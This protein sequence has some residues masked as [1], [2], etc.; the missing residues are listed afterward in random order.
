M[1][2]IEIIDKIARRLSLSD[3]QNLQ[4]QANARYILYGVRESEAN[5]PRFKPHLTEKAHQLAYLYLE[6]ACGY[7]EAERYQE[8]SAYFERGAELLEYNNVTG[9]NEDD[10]TDFNRMVGSLSYYCASQYSKAFI[11]LKGRT[12][13]TPICR[14]LW[15]FLAKN[16][17][18]LEDDAKTI[19][20]SKEGGDYNQVYDILLARVMELTVNYYYYGE[21]QYLGKA[22]ETITDATELALLGE[23]PA[24][25]WLFRLVR[26]LIEGIQ[27]SS[28]WANVGHND[29][30]KVDDGGWIEAFKNVGI[31]YMPIFD[32]SAKL[33]LRNYINSLTFREHPVTELF[34]S[35]RKALEKVLGIEGAVVSMPTSSGK[36]RIAELVILQTLMFDATSKVLYIAPYRSLSFEMEETFN[37]TFKPMEYYVTHLYGSAQ[38]T[39][40]DRQEMEQARVV[41]A[42]PEKAKAILRANDTMVQDIRLVVMDEGHLLGEGQ[43]EVTNEMFSEEL[44]RIV[45][46]NHGRFLVLSAVLPNAEDMSAWLARGGDHVVKDTWRPSSQRFGKILCYPSRIDI[47]WAGEPRCFNPSFVKTKGAVDKKKLIALAA[48]KLSTLGSI[49][50]YCPTPAQVLSNAR[51]MLALLEDEE[52]VDWGNDPDW[53]RFVLVCKECEEDGIYLELAKKGILCHS[54]ALKSDVRRF[55]EHLLRKGKA[56][57]IYATNTLAQG[58]NLG[59]STVIVVGTYIMPDTYLTNRD[60]WNMA[61]RAGRSFVDTE[62]KILFVCNCK[63]RETE[64]KQIWVADKYLDSDSI[65]KVE[66]GV[67]LWLRKLKEMQEKLDLDFDYLLQLIAENNL[68]DLG[69]A[70]YFFEMID[71]SLLSLDLSYREDDNDDAG[72]VEDHFRKSLAVIQ[73]EQ[74]EERQKNIAILKARVHAV[75]RMTQGN[76]MPQAFASSGIPLSVALYFEEHADRLNSLADE[77]LQSDRGID[78]K[79]NYLNRF[80]QLVDEIP[81]SRIIKFEL[82]DLDQIREQWVKGDSLG[83][84]QMAIA[85]KYYGYT[86]TWFMNALAARNALLEEDFYKDFYEEMSLIAQ[87]GLPSKWAVQIYLCGISSRRV[88]AELAAKLD[89]PNDTSRLS[90]VARYIINL[91]NEIQASGSITELA[92]EW[93]KTLLIRPAVTTATIPTIPRF[94]INGSNED[95]KYDR[96]LCKMYEGKAQLC[97]VDMKYHF[98]P[99]EK[100]NMPFSEVADIPGAFFSRD[101]ENWTMECH[102]PYVAIEI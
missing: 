18:S 84:K 97:S 69:D 11:L 89:E 24:R 93:V 44:R 54:A 52:D 13:E 67:Y 66:S 76:P 85:E 17:V 36:T 62:G 37:A 8:A 86:F 10:A 7:Y 43:R 27:H 31:D 64:R 68:N 92:K 98:H 83:Y 96:L 100:E 15:H 6:V 82:S 19:L 51:V 59:V 29:A 70:S 25:W 48:Q 22:I 65:D 46:M 87:Y 16:L 79:I 102:N 20:L 32:N 30:Y 56:K 1:A 9:V 35:Q 63:D 91:N 21:D 80:D 58:V 61:G 75:R 90:V 50:L 14:M 73:E 60:F 81:T 95:M 26:I 72:W 40:I 3:A 2:S 41:I 4:A 5:F 12:Y 39:A 94:V 38:F 57:Y 99:E 42:T 47:E 88:A 53:V 34:L 23:D 71:D 49:L 78:D 77:Y 33:K 45:N 101:G 55:T 28:L 74:E